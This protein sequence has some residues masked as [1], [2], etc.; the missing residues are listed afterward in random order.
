MR[1]SGSPGLPR[2]GFRSSA[3]HSGRFLEFSELVGWCTPNGVPIGGVWA[4]FGPTGTQSEDSQGR[5]PLQA[6]TAPRS[7]GEPAG[8]S[9]VTTGPELKRPGTGPERDADSGRE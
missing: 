6:R 9:P 2:R 4:K 5:E 7:P 1:A 3:A 8:E